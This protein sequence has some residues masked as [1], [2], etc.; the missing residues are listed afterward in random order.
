MKDR[1]K[2]GEART[3]ASTQCGAPRF[4]SKSPTRGVWE[5]S[6]SCVPCAGA[7]GGTGAEG[8]WPHADASERIDVR[9]CAARRAAQVC[10]GWAYLHGVER[11][12][13]KRMLL[14]DRTSLAAKD[15]GGDETRREGEVGRG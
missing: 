15:A 8:E 4:L 13:W 9:L 6:G 10:V 14:P 5:F 3:K 2:A 7:P 12:A 11:W 1:P